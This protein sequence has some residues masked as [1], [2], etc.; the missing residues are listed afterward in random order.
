MGVLIQDLKFGL[1]MLAKNPGFTAIAVITLALGIG[2]NTA[3][4]SVVNGVLLNPL[5]FPQPQRLVRLTWGRGGD[6][7]DLTV[8]QFR[9]YRDHSTVF[10]SSC[11]YSF[12]STSK[13]QTGK[14]IQWV[15]TLSVTWGFF[16]TLGVSPVIGRNFRQE[17][18]RPGGPEAVILTHAIWKNAFVS[19]PK[20]VGRQ[21]ELADGSFTVI[22]VLPAGFQFVQPA[23]AFTPYRF[24]GSAMDSGSNTSAIARLKPGVTLARAQAEMAVVFKQYAGVHRVNLRE[25]GMFVIPYQKFLTGSFR[26][27]LLMLF[28]AVGF[29]LLIAWSN[30]ASL[31]LARATSRQKEISIRLA[32][33][34]SRL[35]LFRQFFIESLL[36]ALAGGTAGLVS[37]DWMLRTLAGSIP[38]NLPATDRITLDVPVLI[39][40]LVI[41]IA[42]SIAF[43]FASFFQTSKLDL[44]ST[45]KEGWSSS[46][47]GAHSRLRKVIVAGEVALSL[48]MLAGAGLLIKSLYNLY[49]QPT[50]F[51]PRNLYAMETPFGKRRAS[52]ASIWNFDRAVLDRIQAIPGVQSAAVVNTLPVAD[53]FNLPVQREGHPEQSIG[54][55]QFRTITPGFFATMNIPLLGGRAITDADT[56][57]S[58]PVVIISESL[59]RKWWG[60]RNPIG[61]RL[62]VGMYGGRTFPGLTESSP[63]VVVGVVGDVRAMGLAVPMQPTI[64][65]PATQ[66]SDTETSEFLGKSVFVVRT[67]G[68]G[69]LAA[70]L[71]KAVAAVDSAQRVSTIEPVT[72]AISGTV[73]RPCFDSLL[74]GIFSA[75]ALVLTAVGLYGVISYSVAQ[76][77]HEI[78]IRMALGAE[79]ID[80]LRMV[81]GQGLKL[82]LIGVAIGIIGA[83]GL[84][85]FLSSLLY[86]VKPTD[87]LTF[88]AVSLL[89]TGVALLACYIPARRATKVDPMVALRQ[90]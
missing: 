83:I 44:N 54:P 5:P 19:D 22:G 33:G 63:R 74:L 49:R 59:A 14:S 82:T 26:T 8:P 84:T 12:I 53:Q 78:G 72:E 62:M 87:A 43:G 42:A 55:M 50:G 31:L 81:I 23:Q 89:L 48:I 10:Q 47:A 30:V 16:P 36:L 25:T 11:A 2:A 70:G 3:I 18:D 73:S 24:T 7:P 45:L 56:A 85:R 88:I 51:N 28:G 17:E 38:W 29:L 41:A 71:R 35:D 27:S 76:R 67:G 60:N 32:M 9:F 15:K 57:A 86:G 13:L 21:V 75:L 79:K 64:Y 90:E 46:G 69:N 6:N 52:A 20:I 61:D 66:A 39:F 80:V 77:T 58:Q 68:A 40:T 65:I 4:F 34:A 1:R 37:A